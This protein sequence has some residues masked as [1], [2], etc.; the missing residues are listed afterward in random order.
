MELTGKIKVINETEAVGKNDF[1]KRELVLTTDEQYP[2][3]ILIEFIQDKCNDLN[4]FGVGNNVE[5]GINIRG[6]E[7]IS[8]DGT[9]KYFNT[10]QGWRIALVKSIEEIAETVPS[11]PQKEVDLDDGLPF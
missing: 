8:P 11:V 10:I 7:W 9:I 6:R 1:R 5:I 4:N 3:D 2:Q